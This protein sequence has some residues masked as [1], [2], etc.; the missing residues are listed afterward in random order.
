MVKIKLFQFAVILHPTQ[1]EQ[2]EGK[3]S[4][5]VVPIETVLAPDVNAATIRAGRA[6][7]EEYLDRLDRLE[8]AVRPF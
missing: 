1:K 6:I 4:E 8:V 7:P 2:E 5:L 3:N